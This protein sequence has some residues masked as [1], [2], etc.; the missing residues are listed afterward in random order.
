MTEPDT[1]QAWPRGRTIVG[2]R[3]MTPD[4]LEN[5]GWELRYGSDPSTIV[6]DDGSVLYPSQ[7]PEGNGPGM[8]FGKLADGST[9]SI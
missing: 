3:P 1:D 4:E 2:V 7:D 9:V 8:L 5:E 6:F